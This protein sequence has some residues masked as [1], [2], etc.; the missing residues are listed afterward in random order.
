MAPTHIKSQTRF[1]VLIEE[2]DGKHGRATLRKGGCE[3]KKKETVNTNFCSHD[4]TQRRNTQNC[5]NT[6]DI[7]YLLLRELLLILCI[8]SLSAARNTGPA[9]VN[10]LRFSYSFCFLLHSREHFPT[11][12][13]K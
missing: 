8:A 11:W 9:P 13:E 3:K 1:N 6:F 12:Q 10:N 5:Y 4:A 7:S 2:G